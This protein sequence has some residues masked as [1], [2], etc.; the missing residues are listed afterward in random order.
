M[1]IMKIAI[2]GERGS[3]HEVAT[4]QY[5]NGSGFDLVTCSSFDLTVDSVV[6]QTADLAV[7]AIE[8]ARSGSI[9]YNYSLIRESGLK[10]IGEHNLRI[11]QNLMALPGQ[12]MDGIRE[13]WSHPIAIAQCHEF[14]NGYPGIKLIEK[15]DTAGSARIIKDTGDKGIAAIGAKLAAELYNLEILVE[16][17]ETNKLNYT[18]FLVLS[19]NIEHNKEGNKASVCFALEHEPGSLASLLTLLADE[20][21]NLTKIQSVPRLLKDW[22]YMFYLDLEFEDRDSINRVFDILNKNTVDL[23]VLGIYSKKRIIYDSNSI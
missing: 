7:I 2:Q 9:L 22:E 20:G 16:N 6:K 1:N 5:F 14:L 4:N 18:R 13:I 21:I 11:E 19:R 3:F 17:I 23:E 12:V 8:N 15:D 10:I